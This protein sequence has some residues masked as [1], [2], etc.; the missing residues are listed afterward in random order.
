LYILIF[1]FCFVVLDRMVVS[2]TRIQS[3]RNNARE[4]KCI[5]LDNVFSFLLSE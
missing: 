3:S 5:R 2:I 4:E 1:V